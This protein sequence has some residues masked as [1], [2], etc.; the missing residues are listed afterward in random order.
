M[1]PAP[2]PA[3]PSSFRPSGR[4]L[5]RH[6]TAPLPIGSVKTN[7]G[8]LEAASGMAGLIKAMLALE[9][10]LLPASLHFETPNPAY[11]VRRRWGWMW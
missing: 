9:H 7:I 3:I 2:W 8:H 6:R 10:R 11:P 1:A 5:A 4:S